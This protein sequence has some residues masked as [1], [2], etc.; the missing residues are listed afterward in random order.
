MI[1]EM[2]INDNELQRLHYIVNN[3]PDPADCGFRDRYALW[4]WAF[5]TLQV[6]HKKLIVEEEEK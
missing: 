4:K 3:Y 5:E 2:E 6:V 1:K